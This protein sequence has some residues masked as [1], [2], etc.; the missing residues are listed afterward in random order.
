MRLEHVNIT[1]KNMEETLAFYQVAF[2]HWQ[3]RMQGDSEWYGVQRKWLHF[4]DEY[5]YLTFND[6][7]TGNGRNLKSN[8]LGVAHLGFEVHNL[9]KVI[10]RLQTAGYAPSHEGAMHPFRKNVYFIDPNGF[11]LEFVQYLSDLP[12]E[13]N[14]G[15]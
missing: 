7:A 14:Q 11:E 10:A 8:T 12:S 5:N 2:P 9:D 6:N 15:E 3:I 1:V 13:R 4:G